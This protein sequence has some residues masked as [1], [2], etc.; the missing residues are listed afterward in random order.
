MLEVCLGNMNIRRMEDEAIG[1]VAKVHQAV[2]GE[3]Q[4]DS[5]RWVRLQ[6]QAYPLN[7]FFVATANGGVVGYILWSEMG[8]FRKDPIL[9]LR[10]MGVLEEFRGLHIGSKLVTE[11]YER[12]K[13]EIISDDRNPPYRVLVTTARSNERAIRL[14]EKTLGAV[15]EG[16]LYDF[17]RPGKDEV[18]LVAKRGNGK[19]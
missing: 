7:Q 13:A 6:S 2:F 4:M 3:R 19:I 15:E 18:L 8:G 1:A 12:I 10:Q 5:E 16:C 11:S 14:Y 17:Y 9:E